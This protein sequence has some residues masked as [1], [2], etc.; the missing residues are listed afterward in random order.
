MKNI[1]KKYKKK[2][3]FNCKLNSKTKKSVLI[4]CTHTSLNTP[5]NQNDCIV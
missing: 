2:R 3:L 5:D 4:S 1:L